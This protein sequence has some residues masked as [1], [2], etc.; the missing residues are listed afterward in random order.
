M[1]T[2]SI[3][4]PAEASVARGIGF[5]VLSYAAFST[6]DAMIKVAS[7][8][9]SVF[10]IAATLSVFALLTVP[11]LTIGVGGL[12]ALRPRLPGL[13]LL[14][15][16]LTAFGA[17]AAWQA[18]ARLPLAEAYAIL[19]GAPILVTALSPVLLGE[20]VGRRRWSAAGVGFA[21][22]LVMIRPDFAT[23]SAGHAFAAAAA[24]LGA[25]SFCVLRRIGSR[26][27]SASILLFLFLSIIAVSLPL[28]LPELVLPTPRDL[29][30]QAVAGL[31]MGAGQAGLV[32][33]TRGT[34]A[35]V[36]AP[37]Q[38]SQMIWALAY[39]LLLFGDRP[40]P[41]M[42]LGMAIV[43]ASGLYIL[44]RETVRR[45]PITLGAA[46]GETIARAARVEPP[47]AG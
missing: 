46:R 10:Q 17:L 19:F 47:P 23:L 2:Q 37:F 25:L 14:R 45:R 18:F 6:A 33:A 36:I 7:A 26:D 42:F 8:G 13:V 11:V 1:Y 30:M 24:V 4:A 9:Y 22:V 20:Q 38:Y 39:G 5:A 40:A 34:P 21:G 15:G 3:Q 35:S 29:L 27:T 44:W 16:L 41:V 32:M 31:L 28:A 12:R 43:V